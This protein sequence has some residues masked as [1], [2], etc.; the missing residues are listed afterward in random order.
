M[1]P[2]Q[3]TVPSSLSAEENSTLKQQEERLKKAT[4]QFETLL[5]TTLLRPT[6]KEMVGGNSIG[7]NS[8]EM[9]YYQDMMEQRLAEVLTKNGGLGLAKKLY[10]EL[11]PHLLG[12][13]AQAERKE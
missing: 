2:I 3:A 8:Y 10:E 1:N 13:N 9:T 7:H 5:L 12:I 11:A 4:Q 6:L